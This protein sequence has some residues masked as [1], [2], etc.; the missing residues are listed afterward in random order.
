MG[1]GTR[2]VVFIS[3]DEGIVGLASRGRQCMPQQAVSVMCC[4]LVPEDS[5]T[6]KEHAPMLLSAA[7]LHLVVARP[8]RCIL[9]S[10]GRRIGIRLGSSFCVCSSDCAAGAAGTPPKWVM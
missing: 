6:V 5:P 4:K 8:Q 2:N 1:L 10:T 9:L 3:Q 7:W